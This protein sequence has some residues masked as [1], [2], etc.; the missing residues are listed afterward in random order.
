[1]NLQ[2]IVNIHPLWSRQFKKSVYSCI[3]ANLMGNSEP[4]IIGCSF[5]AEMKAFDLKG[6][7]VF[8][9]EFASNITCFKIASVSQK[10]SIEL[11]SGA[12]DGHIYVMDIKGNPIWSKK[13]NSPVIFFKRLDF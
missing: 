5:G 1:M 11:I 8:L 10:D 3:I 9:T 12:I 13:L 6:N 2:T 7:E 4:E